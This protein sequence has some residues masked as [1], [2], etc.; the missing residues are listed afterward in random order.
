MY[1]GEKKFVFTRG[2]RDRQFFKLDISQAIA[3][4]VSF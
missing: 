2:G 1:R 4:D 3:F